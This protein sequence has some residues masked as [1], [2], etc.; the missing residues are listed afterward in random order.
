[1][2]THTLFFKAQP[3]V[4]IEEELKTEITEISTAS[5]VKPG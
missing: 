5:A 3:G 1:M 2:A 4:D